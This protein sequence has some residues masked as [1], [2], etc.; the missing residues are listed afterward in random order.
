MI[1]SKQAEEPSSLLRLFG[2][3]MTSR[4]AKFA[5]RARRREYWA[6]VLY[7]LIC[8][9][10]LGALLSLGISGGV[11]DLSTPL[12]IGL[13]IVIGVLAHWLLLAGLSVTV[14]RFHDCSLPAWPV[15]VGVALLFL[16]V[17]LLYTPLGGTGGPGLFVVSMLL[18]ACALIG[19]LGVAIIPGGRKKNRYGIAPKEYAN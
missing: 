4:F 9:A 8:G 15:Y 18:A 13:A 10:L 19:I 3:C 1:P 11:V 16:P 2:L 14:R 12:G 17:L 5:G 6:Y 7:A